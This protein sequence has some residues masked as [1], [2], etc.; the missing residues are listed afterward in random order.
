MNAEILDTARRR[1][2][3]AGWTTLV[4]HQGDVQRLDLGEDFDAV[5]GRWVLM[6]VPD[7]AEMLRK[8]VA[9][10]RPGG[11]VAFQESD[12]RNPVGPFPPAPL[13]EQVKGATQKTG[14]FMRGARR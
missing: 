14:A 6:Y 8:T 13:H 2:D 12:L 5:V 9:C 11:I 4:F 7:P 3:A 1:V 10:L